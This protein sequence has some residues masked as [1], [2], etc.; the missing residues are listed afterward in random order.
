MS[1]R[2]PVLLTSIT[3]GTV[4]GEFSIA[5]QIRLGG[6]DLENIPIAFADA[7]PFRKLNL[8]DRPALLLGMDALELFERVSV[9]FANRRVRL[10]RPNSGFGGMRRYSS[11]PRRPAPREAG[12]SRSSDSGSSLP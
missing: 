3:G 6:V 10:V 4:M 11:L 8:L 12:E 5:P 9:D 2:V 1:E 7:H